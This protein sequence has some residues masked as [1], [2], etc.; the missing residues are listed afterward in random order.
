[1]EGTQMGGWVDGWFNGCVHRLMD[2]WQIHA[3]GQR[4]YD[5]LF[6]DP[7]KITDD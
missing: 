4:A 7:I 5:P 2:Q 1:M 6:E 3:W